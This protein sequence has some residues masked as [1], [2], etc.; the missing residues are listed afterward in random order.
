LNGVDIRREEAIPSSFM[1]EVKGLRK[2][3]KAIDSVSEWTGRI[4][5]WV[6]VVLTVLVVLEV[7]MRRVLSR[8][9]IWNF[10]L[11]IQLYAFFFMIVAAYA[12]LH[13]SHVAVDIIYQK[14]SRRTQA[15]LDVITYTL[16]FFPFLSILFYEGSK[17]AANSWAMRE[18]S[19]SVFA[20]PLYPIKTL[21]PVMAFLLL[22]QG[23]A[24]FIR[25]LHV[26][27]TGDEL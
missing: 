9:T 15:I 8:P 22:L 7:I 6:V 4:F 19:W 27:I 16:F 21:I 13:R 12:L 14:F 5:S 20:P 1:G 11:T 3:L 2:I 10:E 17:Y 18:K 25:R 24:I 23:L 26:A